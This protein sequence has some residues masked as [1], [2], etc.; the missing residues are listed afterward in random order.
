MSLFVTFL[1]GALG[2]AS[3]EVISWVQACE[4]LPHQLPSRYKVWTFWLSRIVLAVL[5][6]S[7]AVAYSIQTPLLAWN[8]GASA[9]L[10]CRM[11]TRGIQQQ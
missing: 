3:I 2:S 6:G 9:P 11:L 7:L 10:L 4:K 1:Y 5:A 8:I